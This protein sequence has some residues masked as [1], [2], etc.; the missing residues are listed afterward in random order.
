MI[1]NIHH[2]ANIAITLLLSL[3]VVVALLYYNQ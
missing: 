3:V 1:G 2:I